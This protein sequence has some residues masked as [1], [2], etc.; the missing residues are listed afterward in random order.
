MQMTD[1]EIIRSYKEALNKRKQIE[2]LSDLNACTRED[3]VNIL[4][5]AGVYNK[6]GKKP[7][8]KEDIPRVKKTKVKAVRS[9]GVSAMPEEAKK[10]MNENIKRQLEKIGMKTFESEEDVRVSKEVAELL[11]ENIDNIENSIK[12][13]RKELFELEAS[14]AKREEDYDRYMAFMRR[15]KVKGGDK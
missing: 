8:K 2:V 13:M 11:N 3:I 7:A 12:R 1:K 4:S 14:I 6:S 15:V 5:A 10:E 9:G